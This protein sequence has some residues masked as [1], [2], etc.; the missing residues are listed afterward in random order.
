[1]K[2]L[3]LLNN[4]ISSITLVCLIFFTPLL[5]EEKPID[6]WNIEKKDNQVISETDIS[7]ENSSGNNQNSVYELQTNK[8]TNSIK[9]DK[10]FSYL[11]ILKFSFGIIFSISFLGAGK[12]IVLRKKIIPKITPN[13][14]IDLITSPMILALPELVFLVNCIYF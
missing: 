9:L 12:S 4:K 5:A 2:I 8:Q 11:T 10:E 7:S 3:K 14:I 1:M 13:P 6:I